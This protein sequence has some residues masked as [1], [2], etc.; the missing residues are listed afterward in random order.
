MY[1]LIFNFNNIKI[2]F[3]KM[4][5]IPKEFIKLKNLLI[6]SNIF[7]IFFDFFNYFQNILIS[8]QFI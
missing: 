4:T 8:V 2:L 6:K 7:T 1:G 5:E 3:F